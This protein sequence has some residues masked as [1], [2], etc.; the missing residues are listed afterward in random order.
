V[1][2]Y[3]YL[4]WGEDVVQQREAGTWVGA[5]ERLVDR[6][7][8]WWLRLTSFGWDQ[9]QTTIEQRERMRRSRLASWIILGL[10]VLTALLA[11]TGINDPGTLG[12]VGVFGLGLVI[13]AALNR[14]G[15]V[16]AA[17][18][19][20]VVLFCLGVLASLLSQPGGLLPLDA[21]PAYD[22]LAIPVVV[23]ASVMPR[24][25][26]FVVAG[27][28]SALIVADFLLQ[29]HYKDLT[30][31][32]QFYGGVA[33]G[34]TAL[35]VRPI[36]LEA[37]IAVVAYLWVRGAD[38]AIRR[39]DRAEEFAAMEHQLADQ[40]R[41]L[42]VGI[43]QILDTHVRVAN[44]DFGA[45]APLGQDN[46][47]FQIAA[48]LNN[49]LNRLGRAAQAEYYLQR[50]ITEINRLRDSLLAARAGRPP[51]WPAPS[52][53]PVD[54]LIEA[55]AG[56]AHPLPPG[57][58]FPDMASPSGPPSGPNRGQMT[59]GRPAMPQYPPASAYPTGTTSG[60]RDWGESLPS[61]APP[62]APPANPWEMPPM[63][64]WPPP[65]SDD[66]GRSG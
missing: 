33:P 8:N 6:R 2:A 13:A 27:A 46:I 4:N 44:G 36:V 66:A 60:L 58:G 52:G 49:L 55:I 15:L 64:D 29:P 41:Q 40:K 59:G 42:D 43:R 14:R 32:L 50:T 1:G 17:G 34:A 9:Q 18:V 30:T 61:A 16:A 51:L 65:G 47:L 57:G 12:A 56:P 7:P 54:S 39:A 19:L 22:L 5:R 63:P 53:T 24:A 3:R 62:G 23:A 48:S 25:S 31:D 37:I 35:L 28:N 21:L 26:A 10:L 20:I 11:F 45:R 38:E